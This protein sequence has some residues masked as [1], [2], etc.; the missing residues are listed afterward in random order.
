MRFLRA[1]LGGLIWI[2]AGVVGLLGVILSVTVVLLPLGIPLLMLAR[3]L[4]GTAMVLVLPRKVRHPTDELK[5]S[6]QKKGDD[7]ASAAPAVDLGKAGK[8]TRKF[9]RRQKKRVAG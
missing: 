7:I 3:K 6:M 9:V 4:F 2:V 8:K 1:L 5:K